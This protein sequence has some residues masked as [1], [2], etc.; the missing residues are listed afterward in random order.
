MKS[1]N[2]H[3]WTTLLSNKAKLKKC[4]HFLSFFHHRWKLSHMSWMISCVMNVRGPV[5]VESLL[6][7]SVLMWPVC[8]ITVNIAGLLSIHAL[9][10]NSTSPWWKREEI[11]QD[12]FHSAGTKWLLQCVHMQALKISAL[13]CSPDS[14]ALPSYS[15]LLKIACPAVVVC[16]LKIV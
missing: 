2:A 10:G 8:S 15:L 9:A 13:F 6:H 3:T 7:F 1:K 12:I 14:F 4:V 5:V 16:N 11:A